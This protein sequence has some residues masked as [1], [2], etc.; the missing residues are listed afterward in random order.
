MMASIRSKRLKYFSL[1]FSVE[2][3][4]SIS[5]SH[6]EY[7]TSIDYPSDSSRIWLDHIG[8]L[9]AEAWGAVSR[10]RWIDHEARDSLSLSLFDY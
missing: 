7:L 2:G 5:A 9:F 6:A 1:S 10:G 3:S 4:S 8:G